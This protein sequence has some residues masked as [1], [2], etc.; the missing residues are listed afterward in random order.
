MFCCCVRGACQR[1][2]IAT[3]VSSSKDRLD[4]NLNCGALYKKRHFALASVGIHQFARELKARGTNRCRARY[5]HQ[6][7]RAG[8]DRTRL[9]RDAAAQTRLLWR[10]MMY[11]WYRPFFYGCN[12]HWRCCDVFRPCTGTFIARKCEVAGGGLMRAGERRRGRFSHNLC[13]PI[14]RDDPSRLPLDRNI[15]DAL[16]G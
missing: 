2:V 10:E 5:N 1:G 12:K 15:R 14:M 11:S 13:Q 8:V 16:Q 3:V 7:V 6:A 9:A 4:Y